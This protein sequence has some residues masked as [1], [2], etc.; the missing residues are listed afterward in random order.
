M[1]S[2]GVDPARGWGLAATL[3]LT[4][5]IIAG[6]ASQPRPVLRQPAPTHRGPAAPSGTLP[7]PIETR[8]PADLPG[9]S[10]EDFAAALAAWRAVCGVAVDAPGRAACADARRLDPADPGAARLFF[11]S[12]FRAMSVAGAGLLTG[13]FAPEY[14]A[15]DAPDE[16][17]CAPVR[18]RP[19]DLERGSDGHFRPYRVRAEIEATPGRAL[20]F[21]RPEDLFF[22][23][24]QGSGYLTFPDGRRRHAAY[25]ADNGRPFVGIARPLSDRKA[26]PPGQTTGDEIRA[27]LADHRGPEAQAVT[28]LNPRY[29]F[30]TLAADDGSGPRGA[31][32]AQLPAGRAAAVDPDWHGWG[33]LLWLDAGGPTLAGA[34]A[35]YR[36]LVVA[37]DT[38]G[39]IRGPARVDLFLGTGARAGDEAGRIKHPMRL[40][41]LVP[42]D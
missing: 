28:D 3:A 14:E 25:A 40:W 5:W 32:G 42:R 7:A 1:R 33:E 11:E 21:M 2:A 38:G 9:W 8:E 41:R 29:V 35:T 12:R 37:L 4:A 39:A 22:M 16:I 10:G 36:R 24:I 30:F 19:D 18:P 13:Y 27:W 31:S 6:C 34:R 23:Q 17:F 20:A 15:R 26:I